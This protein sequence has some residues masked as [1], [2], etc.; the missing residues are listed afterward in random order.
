MLNMR[1]V[2]LAWDVRYSWL[3]LYFREFICAMNVNMYVQIHGKLYKYLKSVLTISTFYTGTHKEQN[4]ERTA[5]IA[6]SKK[7]SVWNFHM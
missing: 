4:R 1:L 5:G 2:F 6:Q 7:S 3:K